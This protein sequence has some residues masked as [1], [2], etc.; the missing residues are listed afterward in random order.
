M[1][2]GTG[3]TVLL[4]DDEES[5]RATL[6]DVLGDEGFRVFFAAEGEGALAQIEDKD[7]DLVI[8]DIWMPGKDGIEVLEIVK[9]RWPDLPVIMISGHGTVETAVKATKIGALISSK[10]R[11]PSTRSCSPSSM[12]SS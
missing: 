6:G 9:R 8:L 10:S 12:P 4:V 7:P 2:K 1:K 11:S 3:Y 5:I